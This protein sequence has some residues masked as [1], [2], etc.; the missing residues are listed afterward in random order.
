[1]KAPCKGLLCA[2]ILRIAGHRLA[3]RLV[4]WPTRRSEP[5][6][7]PRPPAP[8]IFRRVGVESQQKFHHLAKLIP[9][10]RGCGCKPVPKAD[11]SPKGMSAALTA[12]R[13]PA[14]SNNPSK[15]ALHCRGTRQRIATVP[16]KPGRYGFSWYTFLD[17][18]FGLIDS[19]VVRRQFIISTCDEKF[20]QL[21]RQKFRHLGDGAKF[22]RFTSIGA[23]GPS[24]EEIV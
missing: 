5:V 2:G 14:P 1:M 12:D 8:W 9:L 18:L 13:N 16:H 21:A 10:T 17:L 15:V 7:L 4:G 3:E 20:L 19:E 22:Y 23:D 24:V 6:A 11:T